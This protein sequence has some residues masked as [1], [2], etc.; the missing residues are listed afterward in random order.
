MTGNMVPASA[1]GM[2][3]SF[4]AAAG[5]PRALSS[6]FLVSDAVSQVYSSSSFSVWGHPWPLLC[7]QALPLQLGLNYVL[8][9][10]LLPPL[11]PSL[12]L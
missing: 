3:A 4:L 6:M 11:Q 9:P 5:S 2:A 12:L 8:Q 1:A 10:V 7:P